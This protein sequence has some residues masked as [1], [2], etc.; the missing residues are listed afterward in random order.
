MTVGPAPSPEFVA[1]QAAVAG[2]YVVERELGRGGMGVVFL[3]QDVALLRPVA[4]KILAPDIAGRP[5]L[6]AR[7]VREARTV[8]AL[9]HP[10]IVPIYAVEEHGDLLFFVMAYID[11][12]SLARHVERHGPMATSQVEALLRDLGWALGYAHGRGIVHRDV[13]P[14]NVLI[15]RTTGRV[16]L[17]DFGIAQ[18]DV[19]HTLSGPGE[20]VGTLQY[21][22][23]E[24]A[25]G[26]ALDG[27]ADLYALGLVGL[28]ALTGRPPLGSG[29]AP[30]LLAR[31]LQGAPIDVHVLVPQAPTALRTLLARLVARDPAERPPH[32]EAVAVELDARTVRDVTAPMLRIIVQQSRS[33]TNALGVSVFAAV[34]L[35]M[36]ADAAS[37][38]SWMM[39]AMGMPALVVLTGAT[40]LVLQ[41][42]TLAQHGYTFEDLRRAVQQAQRSMQEEA[43]AVAQS[44]LAHVREARTTHRR[45]AIIL[46]G[47]AV[48]GGVIGLLDAIAPGPAVDRW[49]GGFVAVSGLGLL[50]IAIDTWRDASTDEVEPRTAQAVSIAAR[51][52]PARMLT[53]RLGRWLFAW[54]ERRAQRRQRSPSAPPNESTEALAVGHVLAAVAMLPPEIGARLGGVHEL[55]RALAQKGALLRQR[56][57]AA[58]A[59]AAAAAQ[60][61]ASREEFERARRRF[62]A[63]LEEVNAV[64]EGL[65]LDLLRAA[66]GLT[67]DVTI[68]RE[69]EKAR[70]LSAAIDAELHGQSEVR[71]L[72]G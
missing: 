40:S 50:A 13:K 11:G 66:A 49:L 64:L 21:M 36:F 51:L 29:H 52:D 27:R 69:L 19:D 2:R 25:A 70:E 38:Q 12:D 34:P 9:S 37:V 58:E 24:Q 30:V 1:L 22:S 53:S 42:R 23:P 28:F 5:E 10:N 35:W 72:L 32:G 14:D 39:P 20:L 56:I 8:A 7:F 71:K 62:T 41:I 3:A 31:I 54:A 63:R 17:T 4:I 65:R 67:A 57:A 33:L 6:R 47:F 15:E 45:Y 18:R 48:V 46:G 26:A 16:L 59:G 68:S 43:G 61:A 44:A 60:D 55:A